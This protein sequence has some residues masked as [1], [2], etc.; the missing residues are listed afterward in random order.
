LSN[1]LARLS[2][3]VVLA[4][5]A[6]PHGRALAGAAAPRL[7][8]G[9]NSASASGWVG[10]GQAGYNWQRGQFVFGVEADVQATQLKS[11]MSDNLMASSPGPLPPGS[12]AQTTTSVDWYSTL[13]G[14]F[15]VA[16][17]KWLFFGTAGLAFG[18][19]GLT[20]DFGTF[21]L[22][23]HLQTSEVKVGG[24]VGAGVEY[25]FSPNVSFN[26]LYQYI[27]LGRLNASSSAMLV[28]PPT[29]TLNQS[30]STHAQFQT[31]TA[32][33]SW[34]F[35]PMPSSGPWTGFYAGGHAGGAW[36]NSANASYDSTLAGPIQFS[37]DR[38]KRDVVLLG[39]S[40]DGLGIYSFKYHWSD[41]IHVG[42]M[43]QEVALVQP[44][45]VLRDAL[46]GYLAVDYRRLAL[47]IAARN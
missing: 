1:S 22:S 18:N 8:F 14:R 23:T 9:T 4:A 32:G 42:V 15:G 31:V 35:A 20:S 2:V 29:L 3:C 7:P 11:F 34:H 28:L 37:D 5:L 33:L 13:R 10:G 41:A 44:R 25:L 27:D 24:V 19:V 21:G 26:V 40:S 6:L 46:T 45:A 16:A 30:V 38:L 43:A 47:G 12:F 39:R 17:G 36:G